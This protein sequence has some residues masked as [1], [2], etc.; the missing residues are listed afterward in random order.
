MAKTSKTDYKAY[1]K[2]L[3]IA[4]ALLEHAS[5]LLNSVGEDGCWPKDMPDYSYKAAE[6]ADLHLRH[7]L[8][9]TKQVICTVKP[10]GYC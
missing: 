8:D 1:V 5:E 3:N 9:Y 4:V 7:S 2:R 6:S 10:Q